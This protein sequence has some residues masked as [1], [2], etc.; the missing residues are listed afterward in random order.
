MKLPKDTIKLVE[1]IKSYNGKMVTPERMMDLDILSDELG[2]DFTVKIWT[3]GKHIRTSVI[4][5]SY[6]L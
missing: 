5:K 2:E 3:V 1:E 4:Y 6:Q